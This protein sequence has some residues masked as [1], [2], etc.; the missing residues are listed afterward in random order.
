MKVKME[1]LQQ[2]KP[3][4]EMLI[5]KDMTIATAYKVSKLVRAVNEE[6][7][8]YDEMRI[9][10][11]QDIGS[12]LSEDGTNYEIPIDRREE[13]AQKMQELFAVEVD[14]PDKIDISGENISI[15]P[16][17]LIALDSF[18]TIAD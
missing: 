8:H 2:A 6:L 15:S 14:L 18:I 3:A 10:I 1:T 17:L 4:L 16:E 12:T 5:Q 9:K 7:K 11:L 13:F